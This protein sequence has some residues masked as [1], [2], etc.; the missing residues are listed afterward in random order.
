M[1]G[2]FRQEQ[3][4][5]VTT[6]PGSLPRAEELLELLEK[7]PSES[8]QRQLAGKLGA[9]E[10]LKAALAQRLARELGGD[11]DAVAARYRDVVGTT[12]RPA[13]LER[14][15]RHG[16]ERRT[17]N[18]NFANL[19]SGRFTEL[20]FERTFE[21][22]LNAVRVELLDATT[23]RS[24]RD[25]VLAVPSEAFELSVNVKNA[26]VQ[27]RE[28]ERFFGLDPEDT[29]PMATYKA[30]GAQAVVGELLYV[31]LVDWELLSRLRVGYWESL[32]E[33][34]RQVFQA[35][36]SLR[37]FSRALEDAFMAATVEERLAD[38]QAAVGY[39]Q[40]PADRFRTISAARCGRI[41]Y[42]DHERS[43]Y[44][45]RRRMQTDPNVHISVAEETVPFEAV[46]ER[47]LSTP[48][49][50]EDF[51]EALRGTTTMAIPDP[52]L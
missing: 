32:C 26:G 47:H 34:E 38:L 48:E 40:A 11:L 39:E 35:F 8:F 42:E 36:A 3:W 6:W 37:G 27:M 13:T 43:P 17:W 52:P 21:P 29:I 4:Q 12:P 41:F 23:E 10:I 46:I 7:V 1:D 18:N 20:L 22:A 15:L 9:T 25:Y 31:F 51:I 14:L 50:R 28:A 49:R 19:V 16:V 45:Y 33:V 2:G 44:V 5:R 30:F 24:F